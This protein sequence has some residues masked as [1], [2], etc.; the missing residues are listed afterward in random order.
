MTKRVGEFEE[1]PVVKEAVPV[2]LQKQKPTGWIIATVVFALVAVG[3]IGYIVAEKTQTRKAEP[4]AVNPEGGQ[5]KEEPTEDV[6]SGEAEEKSTEDEGAE[7]KPTASGLRKKEDYNG[8]INDSLAVLK[9]KLSKDEAIVV[10]SDGIV[11]PYVKIGNGI[12]TTLDDGRNVGVPEFY[13]GLENERGGNLGERIAKVFTKHGFKKDDS[14]KGVEGFASYT[15][16]KGSICQFRGSWPMVVCGHETWIS[17]KNKELIKQLWAAYIKNN[18]PSDTSQTLLMAKTGDVVN[19][20]VSG[21]KRLSASIH[22]ME[23]GFGAVALFYKKDGEGWK[24]FRSA[25]AAI[26]CDEYTG[27]IAKAFAGTSCVDYDGTGESKKVGE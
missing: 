19:S 3:A 2:P 23:L 18:K 13:N 11:G 9:D 20:S 10:D 5:S 6:E 1:R 4:S 12:Y 25:Q 14:I 27:D 15:D 26:S 8:I 7:G 17:E 22:D 16:G 21:Y 24:Y